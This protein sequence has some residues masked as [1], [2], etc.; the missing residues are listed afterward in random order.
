MPEPIPSYKGSEPYIFV[1]YSHKDSERVLPI[2]NAMI[3]D[4]YRVWY[5]EG[6]PWSSEWREVIENHIRRCSIFLAFLS[7]DYVESKECRSE[8]SYARKTKNRFLQ[9]I[10]KIRN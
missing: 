9:Y 6:I 1:S 2:L 8:I 5:D 7:P 4:G 10:W 3:H